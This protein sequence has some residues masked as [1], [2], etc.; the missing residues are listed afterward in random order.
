MLLFKE[1]MLLGWIFIMLGCNTVWSVKCETDNF[2]DSL[3]LGYNFRSSEPKLMFDGFTDPPCTADA[4][5]IIIFEDFGRENF[6]LF[7]E[8]FCT[9]PRPGMYR[10]QSS[11]ILLTGPKMLYVVAKWP[12]GDG[13]SGMCPFVPK[14]AKLKMLL[15]IIS[16]HFG[17]TMVPRCNL[18]P[19]ISKMSSNALYCTCT[20]IEWTTEH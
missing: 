13:H 1:S 4:Y 8:R 7:W 20:L 19:K 17:R 3:I 5:P 9:N 14:I 15:A 10:W 6:S 12:P 11:R 2:S 16:R 18:R